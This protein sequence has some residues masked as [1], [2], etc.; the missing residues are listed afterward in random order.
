MRPWWLIARVFPPPSY[1]KPA[2]RLPLKKG[3]PV[4]VRGVCDGKDF[5]AKCQFKDCR[6]AL[7]E[8]M[9]VTAEELCKDYHDDMGAADDKYGD[10]ALQIKGVVC[11][12]D[13]FVN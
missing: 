3:Q 7:R 1:C 2:V 4:T 5:K 10:R 6:L 12:Y 13:R 11:Y 8:P 9:E